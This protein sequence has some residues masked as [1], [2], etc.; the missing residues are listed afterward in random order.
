[1]FTEGS[2]PVASE[3]A[4]MRANVAAVRGASGD[5]REASARHVQ[6]AARARQ[7]AARI[8]ADSRRLRG[9]LLRERLPREVRCGALARRLVETHLD[10][11]PAEVD[12]AKMVVSE[13]VNNALVHGAGT[14]ELRVSKR[15][16]RVRIEVRDEGRDA[17]V[18][19]ALGD[20]PRGLDIVE[21]LSLSWGVRAGTT[22]VWAELPADAPS[23]S[24]T[25][26]IVSHGS[27]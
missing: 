25:S 27:E 3:F 11:L 24:R 6:A 4:H 10:A 2:S 23:A 20:R 8:S 16:G 9:E 21:A 7:H 18:R 5:L 1:M 15:G 19:S 26:F 13:L 17:S 12:D 14:I 22:Q